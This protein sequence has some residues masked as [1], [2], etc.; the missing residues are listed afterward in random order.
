MLLVVLSAA[1]FAVGPTAARLAFDDGSNTLTVVALRGIVG[2]GLTAL[3]IAAAGSGF[4]I[5]REAFGAS[6]CAGFACTAMSYGFIGSVA[7][8][9]VS[10]AVVVFFSHAVLVAAMWHLLGRERLTMWKL[11]LALAALAGVALAV[12]GSFG[13]LNAVGVTLAALAAV[14]MCA[15]VYFSARAQENAT[16][17]Q[18]NFYLTAVTVAVFVPAASALD[19][20]ALPAGATGWLGLGAAGLGITI[21]LLAFLAAFRFIGAVKA[22]MISNVEPLLGML[23][24]FVVL[25]ERFQP[26]QWAG[27]TLVIAALLLFEIFTRGDRTGNAP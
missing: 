23:L 13:D 18:V 8:V 6:I 15:M 4:R 20:W 9:P 10:L 17:A 24:A 5:G 1:A 19:A 16:S 27:V 26:S 21:G 3:L 25:G 14:T 7:Y 11:A 22:T 12:G 2:L